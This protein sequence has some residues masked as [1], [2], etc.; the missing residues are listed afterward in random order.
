MESTKTIKLPKEEDIIQYSK[1]VHLYLQ[2]MSKKNKETAKAIS[3]YKKTIETYENTI[4][5]LKNE[6]QAVKNQNRQYHEEIQRLTSI[7]NKSDNESVIS[8]IEATINELQPII[9]MNNLQ[10]NGVCCLIELSDNR[11]ATGSYQSIAVH[12]INFKLNKWMQDI[13]MGNAHKHS[14][15]SLCNIPGNKLISGSYDNTINIW[16]IGKNHLSLLK[17]ITSHNSSVYSVISLT[18]NRFASGSIDKQIKIWKSEEPFQ[19]IATITEE[20]YVHSLLQLKKKPILVSSCENP[21]ISFWNL[22]NYKREGIV[23]GVYV[24]WESHMIELPNGM[25]A[26][27]SNTLKFPIVIID[28]VNYTVVKEI[29]EV[30]FTNVKN[31][32]LIMWDKLSFVFVFD[33]K[34]VQ[35]SVKDY[36]VLNKGNTDKT[37]HGYHGLLVIENGKYLI[38]TNNKNGMTVTQP[39]VQNMY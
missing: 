8:E 31:S 1:L 26:I 11:I 39:Q 24:W 13:F 9:Y 35:I 3:T 37:I 6:I 2:E 20:S 38:A 29:E 12:S 14:V 17:T 4:V 33:G 27:S 21:S 16:K 25:I 10:S 28:T 22:N 34:F 30:G 5:S 15:Y 19:E 36:T 23:R 18:N 32:S 7:I